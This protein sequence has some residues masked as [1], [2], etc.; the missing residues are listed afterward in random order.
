MAESCWMFAKDA[1]A[2]LSSERAIRR[3]SPRRSAI[4]Y[5][6]SAYKRTVSGLKDCFAFL[7]QR[8]A[9][10]MPGSWA[11]AAKDVAIRSNMYKNF[12]FNFFI[13]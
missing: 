4:E 7:R 10:S 6:V 8:S 9:S 5:A 1:H 3:L 12:V 13:I 11:R 2:R